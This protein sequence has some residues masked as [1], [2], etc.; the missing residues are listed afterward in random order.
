[1]KAT[2]QGKLGHRWK[3]SLQVSEQCVMHF[4]VVFKF[5]FSKRKCNH[6]SETRGEGNS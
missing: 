3:Q 6:T 1:M 4:S 2:H 5:Y